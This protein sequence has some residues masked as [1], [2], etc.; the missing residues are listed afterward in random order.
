MLCPNC[1][2]VTKIVNLKTKYGADLLLDQCPGCGGIWFDDQE[3]YLPTH[4]NFEQ[5]DSVNAVA[6]TNV[7]SVAEPLFCPRDGNQLTIFSDPNFPKDIKVES[8]RL[9]GGFWFNR[10]EYAQFFN[11]RAKK[12]AAKDAAKDNPDQLDEQIGKLLSSS[13]G[14]QQYATLGRLGS[15]LSTPIKPNSRLGSLTGI[16]EN[17]NDSTTEALST[18]MM[19]VRILLRLF[20]KV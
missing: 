14:S 2:T 17:S 4:I 6:L 3:I 10:G 16:S 5:I 18:T 1:K 7:V 15:F 13:A 19:I 8:C 20:L 12:I 11:E 9:C